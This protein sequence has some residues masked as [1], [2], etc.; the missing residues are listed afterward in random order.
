[1]VANY[2]VVKF[3]T[4]YNPSVARNRWSHLEDQLADKDF[5]KPGK[6]HVLL[7][8]GSWIKL[9]ESEILRSS[10]GNSIAHKPKLD[11]SYWKIHKIHT[12]LSSHT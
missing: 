2:F 12:K 4:S 6:I 3:I 9:I 5:N 11:I 8:V 1:M 10:D 7:G